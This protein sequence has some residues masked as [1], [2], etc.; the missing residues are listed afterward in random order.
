MKTP[1]SNIEQEEVKTQS[2]AK[3]QEVEESKEI[4]NAL[5][6]KLVG[7]GNYLL[8]LKYNIGIGNAL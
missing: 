7:K 8:I 1:Y 6:E 5:Q 4:V 3:T 2:I